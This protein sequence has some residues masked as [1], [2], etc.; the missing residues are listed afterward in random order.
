MTAGGTSAGRGSSVVKLKG[1]A[2]AR[3]ADAGAVNGAAAD[4]AAV[5]EGEVDE[6]AGVKELAFGVEDGANDD[7]DFG[8]DEEGAGVKAGAATVVPENVGGLKTVELAA[9]TDA[10]LPGGAEKKLA[11]GPLAGSVAVIPVPVP[12][13]ASNDLVSLS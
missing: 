4:G 10:A 13:R 1:D 7:G 3:G 6:P 11:A 9:G 2:V 12:N 8:A 5:L